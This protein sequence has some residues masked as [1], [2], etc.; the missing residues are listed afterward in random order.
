MPQ[1]KYICDTNQKGCGH[2]IEFECLMSELGDSKPKSCPK[3]HKR[4]SL[5]PVF[6]SP[7]ISVPKTLG[8]LADK[9]HAK[10]SDDEKH[11]IIKKNTAYR[12]AKK[13]RDAGGELICGDNNA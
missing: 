7:T 2:T 13:W 9:N 8:G 4:K 12:K 3:C 1:Y 10:M 11:H 5:K 6:F